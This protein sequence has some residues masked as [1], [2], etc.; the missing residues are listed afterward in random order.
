MIDYTV[1]TSHSL[2][3]MKQIGM[4]NDEIIKVE[5][6]LTRDKDSHMTTRFGMFL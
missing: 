2:K 1:K 6:E 5:V 3:K 4:F